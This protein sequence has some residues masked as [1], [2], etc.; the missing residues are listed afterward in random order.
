[1]NGFSSKTITVQ[2][3][4]VR[5]FTNGLKGEHPLLLLHGFMSDATSIVP[6]AEHMQ[7][8][9]PVIVP[10]LPGFGESEALD[11]QEGLRAYVDWCQHFLQAMKIEAPSA[12]IGYSFGAYIAVLYTSLF[13]QSPETKLILL[14]P[15][16]K[17]GWT[18][19]TYGRSFRFVIG[20]SRK[21]AERIYALQYDM[22]TR[23]LAKVRH[24]GVKNELM[25]RRR[26][27][28]AYL[29]PELVIRLFSEFLEIDM[30]SY[31]AR[32][33]VP[34]VI[35]TASEDNIVNAAATRHFSQ[36]IKKPIIMVEILHAGHLLPIEEPM[37]LA[38]TLKN[39]LLDA[40][41]LS[42]GPTR[43]TPKSKQR[44]K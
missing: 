32:I 4:K 36:L 16:V 24:P 13:P 41:G 44:R 31:A 35:V 30:L 14:T 40:P 29:D 33:K 11:S 28:L 19:R 43:Q 6:L 15:V 22:T 18:A 39:Y 20:K 23:Y 2:G 12:I 5:Y 21:T 9:Q 8:D 38:T 1:M 17:L 34:T 27:E 26:E 10:D 37:L 25:E 3:K 7:V 42:A